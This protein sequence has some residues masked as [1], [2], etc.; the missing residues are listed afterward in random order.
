M[1]HPGMGAF[2]AGGLPFVPTTKK[3]GGA[4]TPPPR[5]TGGTPACTQDLTRQLLALLHHLVADAMARDTRHHSAIAWPDLRDYLAELEFEGKSPRTLVGYDRQLRHLLLDYP[6]TAMA[7]FGKA[8]VMHTLGKVPQR[9][10]HITKSVFRGWFAWGVREDRCPANPVDKIRKL[11]TPGRRPSNVFSEAEVAA[12]TSRPSPDGALWALLFGT[13]LRRAEAC[14]LRWGH[15]DLGR[16]RVT[17]TGKRGKTAVV[18]F[19]TDLAMALADFALVEG[20]NPDDYVWNRRKRN[21]ART[22]PISSTEFQRWYRHEL[23]AAGIAYRNP[24]QTRHT[25]HWLLRH[26]EGL[27]LELRQ[28]AMRHSNPETTVRQYPAVDVDDLAAARAGK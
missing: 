23:D 9:S 8:E 16:T 18:P 1:T 21:T 4:E 17:I 13:G 3:A 10:R 20:L 24:H 25:F 19:G 26:V 11:P 22:T 5:H 6:A 15:I 27:D 2:A 28:L 14:N 12:L 7:D